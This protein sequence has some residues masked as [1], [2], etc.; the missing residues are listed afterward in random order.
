MAG[1]LARILGGRSLRLLLIGGAVTA[2][3]VPAVVVGVGSGFAVRDLIFEQSVER[4]QLLA[5]ALAS[6]YEG[7]LDE[8]KFGLALAAADLDEGE[9]LAPAIEPRLERVT[10]T[11]GAF[12][13]EVFVTDR[14]GRT[15]ATTRGSSGPR[16]DFSDRPW[17]QAARDARRPVVERSV[18]LSRATG[19]P[20]VV[21][22]APIV[23]DS[24]EVVGVIAGT[25]QLD[26]LQSAAD[27]LRHGRTGSAAVATAQGIA[28]AH[29]SKELTVQQFDF[30]K[31]PMWS[32]IS[33]RASGPL[34]EYA[35]PEGDRRIG[36]FATVAETGWKVWVSHGRADVE[37]DVLAAY[38]DV[39]VW[40]LAALVAAGVLAAVVAAFIARPVEALR[41]AAG[42]I[43]AGDLDRRAA[44][45]GPSEL[46][47]LARAVN[48][49]AVA[50]KQR[51]TAEREAKTQLE[52]TVQSY[53]ALAA[54][55][56][57]GDLTSR[58]RAANDSE[59]GRLGVSLDAMIDSLSGLVDEI[60]A[61][62]GSMASASAEILAA[63]SQQV[64]ATQEESTAVRQT[65][66]TVAE[67][68]QTAELVASR[69]QAMAALAKR[70]AEISAEGRRSIDESV[71]GSEKAKSSMEALAQRILDLSEQVQSV[72]E[73]NATV[74]DLA[75]QSNL[76][77]VNAEIEAAKAGEAGKGF[78]VVA[79]EVK[80]LAEQCKGATAQ[81]RGI[82]RDIQRATQAAM[83]SAEQGVKSAENGVAIAARSG[84]AIRSLAQAV[85]DG[86]NAAQQ[87][88]ASTQQQ[89][90]GMD[91]I[92][93]AMENI[94]QSSE[95]TVSATT[96]V[97][98]SARQLNG[99]AQRLAGLV[100]RI[101][102]GGGRAAAE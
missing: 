68:N 32:L 65:A 5:E 22:A 67:V 73:I 75:E 79:A 49:M 101:S 86:A 10:R 43:A 91:Q 78:A 13:D 41:S 76:L 57:K 74:N 45:A 25:L 54:R 69:A 50:L 44:E 58:I 102:S 9:G 21:I 24:A 3:L 42:D 87:I 16:L 56:A 29:P 90:V 94:R 84:D 55:V 39:G 71:A 47:E 7:F 48:G 95:Q 63:T 96:Q 27:R 83:L 60:K 82:L 34:T 26:A 72:A 18:L 35:G 66:A 46:V 14:T 20:V 62:A 15:V 77:A 51:F 19:R 11:Y 31:L 88:F 52:S 37:G 30:S 1:T 33:A 2:A 100:D 4:N 93:E 98:T 85:N 59:L 97:E 6:R 36:G 61:A 38:R 17:F 8:H 64:A 99:L 92:S 12:G 89:T 23:S 40:A 28:L 70:A 53:G 81:V 80:S